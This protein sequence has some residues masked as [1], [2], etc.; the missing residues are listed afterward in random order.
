[1]ATIE[2]HCSDADLGPVL[3]LL[4]EC[5]SGGYVDAELL[6][7]NLRIT[8]SNPAFD[9]A[10]TRIIE[11]D[12][13][14]LGFALL[15]R[16]R[17]LGI[18]VH[19][20]QRGRLEPVLLDW[21]LQRHATLPDAEPFI[22]LCRDD[23]RLLTQ[24]F[25]QRG[26]VLDDEELRMGRDLDA[27]LPTDQPSATFTIRPLA[28]QAELDDWLALY[29]EA[30]G[31]RQNKLVHWRAM[32]EDP[33]HRPELDL[34]A[35][36]ADDR[37]AGFCYC[38]I[39][40]FEAT[41]LPRIEGRTEPIAVGHQFRRRGLGRALVAAGIQAL[42][43]HGAASVMLTTEVDNVAAHQLYASLGYREWYRARWYGKARAE[44]AARE[45]RR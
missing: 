36:T 9:R 11:A 23:D 28:S 38:S 40:G 20:R 22:A 5:L 31:P 6:S 42:Q 15:W 34:V 14:L 30:F 25:E 29:A 7:T 2:R 16:G 35:V 18:L 3:K 33:D 8:L 17:A 26:F 39:A 19:P 4:G 12:G 37:L 45:D 43:R 10:N 44:G 13:D 32:R 21:A 27:N 41:L 24:L 1:M